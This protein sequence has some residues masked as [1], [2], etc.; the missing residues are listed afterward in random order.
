MYSYMLR[1]REPLKS[2]LKDW[3]F[4]K[5]TSIFKNKLSNTVEQNIAKLGNKNLDRYK[6]ILEW[7]KAKGLDDPYAHVKLKK[8]GQKSEDEEVNLFDDK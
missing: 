2:N 7:K 8:E 1:K 5:E 6:S 3:K 4:D